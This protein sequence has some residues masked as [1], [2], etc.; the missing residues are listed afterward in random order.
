M[1]RPSL[2]ISPE[3]LVGRRSV[4]GFGATLARLEAALAPQ[5]LAVFARIDH[6]EAA[7]AAGLHMPPT[8]VLV[9]GAAR[10]GTRLMIEHPWLAIDLPL[11]VLV[12]EPEPGGAAEV[13]FNDPAWVVAR[14]G[15]D[16]DV[17]EVVGMRASLSAILTAATG[18]QA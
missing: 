12:R 11:R 3:G 7:R 15:V 8:V 18:S 14:H 17:R 1:E 2:T 16:G 9:V 4:D 13:G 10:A 5:G 6:G